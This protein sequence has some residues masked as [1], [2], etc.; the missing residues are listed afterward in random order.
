MGPDFSNLVPSVAS[1]P[2]APASVLVA[3]SASPPSSQLDRVSLLLVPTSW[4][5]VLLAASAVPVV[6]V[7][8]ARL[9]FSRSE[10]SSPSSSSSQCNRCSRCVR[11]SRFRDTVDTVATRLLSSSMAVTSSLMAALTSRVDTEAIRLPSSRLMAVT[12]PDTEALT[13]HL[14]GE[15]HRVS[16][17]ILCNIN[18]YS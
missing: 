14:G 3:D 16:N 17:L 15:Y 10:A 4:E 1:A 2:L 7:H 5:V 8:S 18:D 11:F 12:P 9:V 6:S 13:L